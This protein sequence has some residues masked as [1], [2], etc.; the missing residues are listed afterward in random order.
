MAAADRK[1]PPLFLHILGAGQTICQ[2][3]PQFILGIISQAGSLGGFGNR[4]GI[5]MLPLMRTP[6]TDKWRIRWYIR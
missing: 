3:F 1:K 4:H 5:F 2:L 6:A